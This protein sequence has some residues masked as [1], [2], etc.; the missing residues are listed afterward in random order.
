MMNIEISPEAMKDIEKTKEYLS[1]DFGENVAKKNIKKLLKSIS[2]LG[3]NPDIGFSLQKQFGIECD[4]RCFY[5]TRNYI[6]FRI[7]RDTVKV[8]RVLDER[9]DFLYVL[10]GIKTQLADDF[11]E[12]D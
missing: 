8:V 4:Y 6:F 1:D 3:I 11:W 5:S 2:N 7:E 12:D 9:R 10:F